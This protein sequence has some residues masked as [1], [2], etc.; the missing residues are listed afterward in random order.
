MPRPA[1]RH[2]P[3]VECLLLESL[4]DLQALMRHPAHLEAKAAQG[5]R[6]DGYRVVIAEVPQVDGDA[7]I[8]E[9]L[10]ALASKNG[11]TAW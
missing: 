4:E 7:R 10:T 2:F 11:L 3:G 9:L 6:L 8:D 1:Q 5:N